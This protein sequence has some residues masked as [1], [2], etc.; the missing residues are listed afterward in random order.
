MDNATFYADSHIGPRF[1]VTGPAWPTYH[2]GQDINRWPAGTPI[3]SWTAGTV[4]A[5]FWSAALGYVVQVRRSDG[6]IASYCHLQQN[7][8]LPLGTKVNIGTIIGKLGSTGSQTTGPHLHTTLE[9]T[10]VIGTSR[11]R[12]PLPY[13]KA[14]RTSPAGGGVTP[15]EKKDQEVIILKSNGRGAWLI[16]A[17][18]AR[19]IPTIQELTQV[20]TLGYNVKDCGS[21]DA[22]F[23]LLWS[24][25]TN[26]ST[27]S[28]INVGGGI[29][30][31]FTATDRAMLDDI[32]SR[33]EL[34][35]ALT[36]TVALVNDHADAN[37]AEIL[38]AIEDA[39]GGGTSGGNYTLSLN[40]DGVPGTAN[41]TAT[42]A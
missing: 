37:K 11:A 19:H 18:Y 39:P 14:S 2:H 4:H 22:A 36:S 27:F 38:D 6:W 24:A 12:D 33:D 3:P 31:G 40:I 21:N 34:T 35:S 26:I 16:G 30:G 42:P 20:E 28:N 32:A 10:V 5:R 17:G 1:G 23:D 8:P 15:I 41:G 7:S 29:V 25:H 9:P 13:I